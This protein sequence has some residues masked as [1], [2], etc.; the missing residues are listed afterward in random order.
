MGVLSFEEAVRAYSDTVYRVA[1]NILAN[2]EDSKDAMQ[3]VFLRYYKK[4]NIFE[5]E[6]HVKAWLIRVAVNESK[7]ILKHNSKNQ[8]VSLDEIANTLFAESKEEIGVYKEVMK[9]SSKYR[10]V[11]LL[12]Y[13]EGYTVR[14]IA[15]ILKV[16]PA[17]VRTQLSRARELLKNNLKEIKEDYY[18]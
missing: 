13:Y 10:T 6:E 14:D 9:L 16:N 5:S 4:Q 8:S 2:P 15:D 11:I 3:N 12:Y 1:L 7:R 17:T 18:E